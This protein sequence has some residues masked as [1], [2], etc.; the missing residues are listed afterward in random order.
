MSALYVVVGLVALQRLVELLY[1]ERNT[2]LLKQAGAVE[3]GRRQYPLFIL[4][5]GAWLLA[6]VTLVRADQPVRWSLLVLFVA[7]QAMRLWVIATLGRFWT[8]RIITI[9]DAPLVSHGAYRY[10]RHPNYL[11]VTAEIATLPLAFGAFAIAG[12][13]TVLNVL[14]LAWRIKL[15]DEALAPRRVG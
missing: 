9:R 10:V 12:V 7:L 2:R 11:I 14:L 3:I 4:L 1:A 13:F 5:H 15:E 6:L 8:A